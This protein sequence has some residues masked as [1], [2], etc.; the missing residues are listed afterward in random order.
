MIPVVLGYCVRTA[1]ANDIRLAGSDLQQRDEKHAQIMVYPLAV[2]LELAACRASTGC[3][4]QFSG[5]GL[6]AGY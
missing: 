2:G 5:S 6:N 3:I 4:F 1:I